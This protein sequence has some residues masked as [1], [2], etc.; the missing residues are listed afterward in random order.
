[1]KRFYLAI[2]AAGVLAVNGYAAN[3]IAS[4]VFGLSDARLK[5]SVKASLF[6]GE[7][8]NVL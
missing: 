3:S 1:M 8:T 7:K 4:S 2:M 6:T 5:N